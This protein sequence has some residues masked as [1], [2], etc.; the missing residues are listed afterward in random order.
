MRILLSA[1][2]TCN[3]RVPI[4]L[5]VSFRWF[6]FTFAR[7]RTFDDARL[8]ALGPKWECA[9]QKRVTLRRRSGLALSS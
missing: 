5:S 1:G 7:A 8:G 2:V 9:M 4:Y 6:F 3:R